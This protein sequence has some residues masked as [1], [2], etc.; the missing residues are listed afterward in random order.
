MKID[1]SKLKYFSQKNITKFEELLGEVPL[2]LVFKIDNYQDYVINGCNAKKFISLDK[3]G[4][5][6]FTDKK[7]ATYFDC[8]QAENVI[9]QLGGFKK[10]GMYNV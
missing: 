7:E 10:F 1:L 8:F 2:Y 9:L 6:S 5:V 4:N 3:D